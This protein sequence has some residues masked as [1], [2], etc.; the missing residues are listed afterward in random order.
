MKRLFSLIII[1]GL[2]LSGCTPALNDVS[3]KIK[4]EIWHTWN[5][6]EGGTEHELKVIVD[7]YNALHDDIEVVLVSQPSSGFANKVYTSA[8]NGVG[9]DIYFIFAN[10]LPEYVNANLLADMGKYMDIAELK[11][12]ISA[13][14]FEECTGFED[15]RLHIVPIQSTVS[16][17]FYNQSIYEELNLSAPRT[18]EDVEKNAR[19]IYEAKGIPGFAV[20][21]YVDLGQSL[22]GQVGAEYI[23]AKSRSIGF[24]TP[25]CASLLEWYSSCVSEGIFTA[26][27]ESGSIDQEF[28]AGLLGSFMGTCSYEPY[29]IPNGFDYGVAPVPGNGNSNWTPLF[30]RGACV[31]ASDEKTE[32]AA[33]DFLTFFTD[34]EHSARW[35][36]AIGALS[37]YSDAALN[38][39]YVKNVN[40]S[41][42]LQAAVVSMKEAHTTAAVM[43][44]QTVRNEMKEAFLQVIGKGK[45]AEEALL[46]AE[47][48]SNA[49]LNP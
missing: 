12:R 11:S 35:A 36:M 7:E 37:P 18:W 3:G 17:V 31:L 6:E 20:D 9:P 49:A 2:L 47:K 16:V 5:V 22:F 19:I 30:S 48:N 21:S 46:N 38:P 27:F 33:C 4:V 39:D 32:Q 13:T 8:A 29:I 24:N 26:T 43:G 40:N 25:E 10:T 45:T 34:A 23:D 41:K 15:G 44:A 14:Q 42:V 1:V 28:N